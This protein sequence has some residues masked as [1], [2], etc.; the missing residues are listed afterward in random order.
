MTWLVIIEKIKERH[1]NWR[2]L[3][4]PPIFLIS[5]VCQAD[6]LE[7]LRKD[8]DDLKGRIQEIEGKQTEP[9]DGKSH[10]PHLVY[11]A[12]GAMI[13]GGLTWFL[14]STDGGVKN[15]TALSYS[16]DLGLQ[17]PVSAQ[18]KVVIALEAGD[19]K[20]V[21]PTLGSLSAV[22]YDPYLT[23]LTNVAPDS[24]N[25]VVL[26]VSQAYYEGTYLNDH[27][28]ASF[29]KLDVHSMFD[30]N[31]YANDEADQFMSA[32]FVRSTG[33]TFAEL[34]QY[35]APGI[36]LKYEASQKV[37]LTVIAAN[38]NGDGF[39]DVFDNMYLV[40]QIDIKPQ[41]GGR[42][43][44]YRFYAISDNRPYMKI[45]GDTHTSNTAWGLSFD[46]A[47][48]DGV[49]I[50]ARYSEQ[51][52]GIAENI[53]KSS[54][55]LGALFEG[56]LWGRDRDTIGIGYGSVDLNDETDLTTALGTNHTGDESHIETFY[57]MGF[58][59]HFTL[60]ADVQIIN[61]NGGNAVADTVT[62]AGLRGQLNF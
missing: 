58:S 29:G 28:V 17:A 45:G 1:L 18:G 20:G 22:G 5:G 35:Y 24:A 27:L 23:N 19:G 48:R 32:I 62:V 34:D 47:V 54:W 14:Q 50:F 8:I 25:V 38:G 11:S 33:T 16:L 52:D 4:L 36:A 9:R 40:G 56:A 30:D 10:E 12:Y 59:N 41:F 13:G 42:D 57:K 60:T 55:S 26:S 51:D 49:G 37:E 2:V 31:A 46:Q 53:V 61:N 6:E 44:N 7:T 21:G 3:L 39:N 43:G 15:T